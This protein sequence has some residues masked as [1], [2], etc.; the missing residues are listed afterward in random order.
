VGE[1]EGGE[2]EEDSGGD[3]GHLDGCLRGLFAESIGK[4]F[5]WY[6]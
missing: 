6:A 2:A 5:D 4:E 3:G 1:G